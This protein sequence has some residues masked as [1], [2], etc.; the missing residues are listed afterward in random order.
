[1]VSMP[2]LFLRWKGNYTL[3]S[4]VR[5]SKKGEI[6]MVRDRPHRGSLNDAM[7]EMR[8]VESMGRS[9]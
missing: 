6:S 5:R 4:G 8:R 3:Y 7:E 2:C 9:I 1:M